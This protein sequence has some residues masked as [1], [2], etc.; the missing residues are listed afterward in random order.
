MTEID[1][2]T[3]CKEAFKLALEFFEVFRPLIVILC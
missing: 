1:R 3:V 2:I